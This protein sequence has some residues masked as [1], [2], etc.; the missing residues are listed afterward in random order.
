[1][2]RYGRG[3]LNPL[4][5]TLLVVS[6]LLMTFDVRGQGT[7]LTATLRT[8]AQSIAAPLQDAAQAVVD[9]VVDFVDGLANLTSLRDENE[10]LR[11]E[12]NEA[13]LAAAE[14]DTLQARV[15]LLEQLLN[16]PDGEFPRIPAEVRGGSGPLDPGLTINQGLERGV[17]VGNPVVD[18]NDVLVGVITEALPDSALVRLI[19][20]PLSGIAVITS[21][22]Q[23]GVLT[24]L[25]T[26]DALQLVIFDT[27]VNLAAGE[28]LRTSGTQ[29]GIPAGIQVATLIADARV[30]GGGIDTV[31]VV[32]LADGRT[33]GVVLIVQ[34]G[35]DPEGIGEDAPVDGPVDE[36]IDGGSDEGAGEDA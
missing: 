14:A 32:P 2:D 21:A 20:D 16:L 13:R 1:M 25:G 22:D 17:V 9:P 27:D 5:I 12:L 18:E 30:N 36:P 31:D 35:G 11:D 29:A 6:F 26:P 24:G 8:G 4:L 10:R 33:L 7:G 23:L 34:F 3:N 15:E 28:V 19:T